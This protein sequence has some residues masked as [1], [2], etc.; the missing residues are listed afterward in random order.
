MRPLPYPT[1]PMVH[2]WRTLCGAVLGRDCRGGDPNRNS[3]ALCCAGPL[4]S[5]GDPST[6]S[7]R[8]ALTATMI[9]FRLEHEHSGDDTARNRDW[10]S[11]LDG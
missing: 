9:G 6:L 8:S 7:S 11:T 4:R 10:E 5:A 1:Y 3:S 2:G